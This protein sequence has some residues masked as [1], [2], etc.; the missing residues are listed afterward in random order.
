MSRTGFKFLIRAALLVSVI[1]VSLWTSERIGTPNA[2]VFFP[3]EMLAILTLVGFAT[4]DRRLGARR[5]HHGLCPTCGYD[6]RA[7]PA[8]CPE[9]GTAA[10]FR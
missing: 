10:N 2:I 4:R 1:T 3:L 9:C 5:R 7:T 8:R 6:L